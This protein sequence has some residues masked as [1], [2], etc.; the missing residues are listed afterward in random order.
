MEKDITNKFH[1]VKEYES[2][3]NVNLK[4]I[5]KVTEFLTIKSIF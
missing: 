1:G 2:D 5:K 3:R 4:M